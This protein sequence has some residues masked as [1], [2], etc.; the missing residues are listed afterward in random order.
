MKYMIIDISK[1]CRFL[2][3]YNIIVGKTGSF[4]FE[5]ARFGY[6]SGRFTFYIPFTFQNIY[7]DYCEFS[8][9]IKIKEIE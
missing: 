2:E 5:Y 1:D 6:V 7:W 4:N 9:T 8:N 3:I